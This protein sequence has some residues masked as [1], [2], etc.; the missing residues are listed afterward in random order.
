M[1]EIKTR[2]ILRND[3]AENWENSEVKLKKG[4][5][6]VEIVD[7]KAK[8]KIATA[9]DQSFASAAYVG[10]AEANVFQVE[11]AADETDI[12][13][14][15]DEVVG[16]TE[17]AVGDIAI[18]KAT[19]GDSDKTSYTS[20]VYDKFVDEEGAETFAWTAMD[21][22]YSATNVY[23][24]KSIKLTSAVGNYAKDYKPLKRILQ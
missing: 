6:A 20:Y 2:I 22:N 21:G 10:G 23:L 13:A 1:A 11:L 14:A 3:T 12:E 15:I 8:L 7:G 18:V 9:D 19:I 24:N 17:L 5:S 16:D 4:E